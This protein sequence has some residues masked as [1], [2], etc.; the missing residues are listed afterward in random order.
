MEQRPK[1]PCPYCKIFNAEN[2]TP[3][4]LFALTGPTA[5]EQDPGIPT[6][7]FETPPGKLKEPEMEAIRVSSE[8]TTSGRETDLEIVPI[9]FDAAIWV[10]DVPAKGA[11]RNEGSQSRQDSRRAQSSSG[12][13]GRCLRSNHLAS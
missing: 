8:L 11:G 13:A 5:A 10:K 9:C 2:L 7:Y 1:A 4:D 12:P 6:T 3:Q